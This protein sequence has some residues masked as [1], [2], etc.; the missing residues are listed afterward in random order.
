MG[1]DAAET[2]TRLR[3][4]PQSVHIRAA[5]GLNPGGLRLPHTSHSQL[6][7]ARSVSRSAV[8]LDVAMLPAAR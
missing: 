5:V 3:G 7:N 8:R 2:G 4:T 6:S 1:V